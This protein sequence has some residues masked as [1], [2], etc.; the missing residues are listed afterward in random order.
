MKQKQIKLKKKIDSRTITAEDYNTPL[1][2]GKQLDRRKDFTA[3]QK[4]I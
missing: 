1:N 4:P 3:H 2:H